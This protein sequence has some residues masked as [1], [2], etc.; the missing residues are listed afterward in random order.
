MNKKNFIVYIVCLFI[1]LLFLQ[2]QIFAQ[3]PSPTPVAGGVIS[4]PGVTCGN[5][6]SKDPTVRL[7]CKKQIVFGMQTQI[8]IVSGLENLIESMRTNPALQSI[9]V[10]GGFIDTIY[11]IKSATLQLDR[12]TTPI[13]CP[14]GFPSTQDPNDPSCTCLE[15]ITPSPIDRLKEMCTKYFA[16]S[17][18]TGQCQS[19]A[20]ASGVWT[21]LGCVYGDTGRFVRET[22]FGFAVGLAGIVAL[23]CII[24]AAFTL[25]TSRGNPEKIKK[26]QELLTSCIMG[27]ML[28]LFSVFILRLIGVSILKIPGF[29]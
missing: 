29:G 12:T 1:F 19:C 16:N 2:I 4:V 5:S 9:P 25:Q 21:G 3:S 14:F 13:A 17:P 28:I 22:I 15:A 24:Y 11:N 27:L 6:G 23:I 20:A 10:I 7:C 18:E 26:A 8:P